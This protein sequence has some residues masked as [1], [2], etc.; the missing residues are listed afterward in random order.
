LKRATTEAW[1]ESFD[2][3]GFAIVEC[4]L[5]PD[6][7]AEL[8]EAT[9]TCLSSGGE[10]VLERDGEVYG[11]RDLLRRVPEAGRLARSPLLLE[12]VES[13]LGP[14]AF[15]VRGLFFDK[16]LRTN[17]NLPWHQAERADRKSR[18]CR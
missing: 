4:V 14:G 11:V 8:A 2:R 15:V 13:I 5:S 12:I 3:D 17:W 7:V 18:R 6:H 9:R 16:T 1:R 10:G